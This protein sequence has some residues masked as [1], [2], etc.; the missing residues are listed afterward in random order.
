MRR[1]DPFAVLLGAYL[2]ALAFT[3]AVAV[4]GSTVVEPLAFVAGGL[5]WLLVTA[6][7]DQRT[8]LAATMA[9]RQWHLA[10]LG[11]PA[12]VLIGWMVT[13]D[14]LPAADRTV[15]PWIPFLIVA[16][17]IG[18]GTYLLAN[19]RMLAWSRA[20]DAVVAEWVAEPTRRH[21]W[22][23]RGLALSG[24]LALLGAGVTYEDAVFLAEFAPTA[25]GVLFAAAFFVGGKRHYVALADGLY[26]KRVGSYG[27]EFIPWSRFADFEVTESSLALYR[28]LPPL[29]FRSARADVTDLP[30][31]T[32]ALDRYLPRRDAG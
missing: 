16:L 24:A 1:P 28:W 10:L 18:L 27:G 23:L 22:F 26:V 6:I 4:A 31:I 20:N 3:L 11:V 14:A 21:T 8:H 29:A 9:R 5:V 2:G 25:A 17:V 12:L 30:A 19:Q 7:A 13:Y 32:D 15:M